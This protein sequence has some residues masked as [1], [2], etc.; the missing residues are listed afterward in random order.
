MRK[1]KRVL[2]PL[3][4]SIFLPLLLASSAGSAARALLPLAR[5][6][7][8]TLSNIHATSIS[9]PESSIK[10]DTTGVSLSIGNVD[11][12]LNADWCV[13][14]PFP[15]EPKGGGRGTPAEGR[16]PRDAGRGTPQ[17]KA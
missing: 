17:R 15:A 5:Q 10:C 16:R 11:A 6:V 8:F 7:D 4:P 14:G 1:R 2:A 9:L 12:K 3:S 13:A